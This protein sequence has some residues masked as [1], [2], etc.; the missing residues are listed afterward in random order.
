MTSSGQLPGDVA[1]EPERRAGSAEF[2]PAHPRWTHAPLGGLVFVALFD[3][4]SAAG[5]T[6][7]W[8]R[9]LYR[10]GTLILTAVLGLLALAI[11]TG[12]RDRGRATVAR[13]P[14]REKVNR[15]AGVM[16]VMAVASTVDVALRRLVYPDARHTPA[17]VLAATAVALLATV[18]GGDLG[19]RLT[20]RAGVGVPGHDGIE[21]I[22]VG[23][24]PMTPHARPAT[25][26]SRR[27]KDGDGDQRVG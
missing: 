18:V 2:K 20:Y 22:G 19:G 5:D 10:S 3:A 23:E 12:L 11:G 27:G 21:R 13:T 8:A 7:P 6:R 17:A 24:P 1:T 14:V 25:S 15:H 4:V 26:S 9:D 16:N